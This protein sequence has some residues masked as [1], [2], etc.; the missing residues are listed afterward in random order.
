MRLSLRLRVLRR[1]H[2]LT[3]KQ[4]AERLSITPQYL[5]DIEHGRRFGTPELVAKLADL[6]PADV[7]PIVWSRDGARDRGWKI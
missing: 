7:H 1:R 4:L 3:Q 6:F 2:S 5:N